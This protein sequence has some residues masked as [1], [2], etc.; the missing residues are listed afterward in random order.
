[1]GGQRAHAA[2]CAQSL[3]GVLDLDA[4]NLSGFDHEDQAGLEKLA[5]CLVDGSDWPMA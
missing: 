3:V 1:M 4:I 5:R 2:P